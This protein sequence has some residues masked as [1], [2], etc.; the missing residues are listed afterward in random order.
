MPFS[1]GLRT[2]IGRHF[3][4][5]EAIAVLVMFVSRYGIDIKPDPRF[6]FETPEARRERI[7]SAVPG[8]TLT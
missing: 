6:A 1:G 8:I 5:V 4:E 3:A 2:C 7:L